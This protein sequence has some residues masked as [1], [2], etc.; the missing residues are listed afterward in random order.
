MSEP[1]D[2]NAVCMV[3]RMSIT[4]GGYNNLHYQIPPHHHHAGKH[5]MAPN[6]AYAM[7]CMPMPTSQPRNRLNFLGAFQPPTISHAYKMG[8]LPDPVITTAL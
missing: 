6:M 1:A 3:L 7:A 4:W 2:P 8:H 5:D